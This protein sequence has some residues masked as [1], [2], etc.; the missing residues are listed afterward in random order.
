MPKNVGKSRRN[1]FYFSR[2][3]LFVLNPLNK[4]ATV[5]PPKAA[6]QP[7]KAVQRGASQ[8]IGPHHSRRN[9]TRFGMYAHSGLV[10]LV[11]PDVIHPVIPDV[12]HAVIPDIIYRES[13]AGVRGAGGTRRSPTLLQSL[14]HGAEKKTLDSR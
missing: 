7:Q 10:P 2:F 5:M 14:H 9:P 8:G 4:Q 13:N 1:A 11:I 3:R 6:Y 12:S